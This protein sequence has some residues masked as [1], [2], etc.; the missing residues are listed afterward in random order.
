VKKLMAIEL[1]P[2]CLAGGRERKQG[3]TRFQ[4][5]EGGQSGIGIATASAFR[6]VP[7]RFRVA[8]RARI[9]YPNSLKILTARAP[10]LG[11]NLRRGMAPRGK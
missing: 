10:E 7:G 2:L 5:P 3:K 1:R 4:P 6:A 8:C 11:L 9:G